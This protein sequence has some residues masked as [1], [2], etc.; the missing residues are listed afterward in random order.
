MSHSKLIK[1]FKDHQDQQQSERPE[2]I[3]SSSPSLYENLSE[4]SYRTISQDDLDPM[5]LN[6]T[7]FGNFTGLELPTTPERSKYLGPTPP[8]FFCIKSITLYL[9]IYILQALEFIGS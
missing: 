8:F 6:L 2:A 9:R 3:L 5:A 7:G 1:P 4:H